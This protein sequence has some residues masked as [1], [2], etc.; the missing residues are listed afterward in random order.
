MWQHHFEFLLLG[1]RRL[2]DVRRVLQAGA[3]GHPRPAHRPDGRR[4][5][6]GAVPGRR[7]AAP[8]RAARDRHGRRAGVRRGPHAR[9]RST[10][11]S[12]RATRAA[13]ARGARGDQGPVVQH[14][15]G[16]RA[17]PLLRQLARRPEHPVRVARRATSARSRRAGDIERPTE[18][19][20]RERDRLAEEY[21]A[22][23][24]EEQRGP[25]QEL[26][27]PLA[28]GLPVR[29]GAQVL[30]R[31]LVPDRASSTRCASSAPC[32]RSTATSR[33][34][35]TSSSSRATRSCRRSRSSSL[36]WATGGQPLGPNHWPPIVARRKELLEQ[37]RR[38]DPAAGARHDARGGERP[39]RGDALGHHAGAPAGSG[40]ATTRAT[41]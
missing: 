17:L 39:D 25:F 18:E 7:R 38:L 35:R 12:P 28:H 36:H 13:L 11:S 41:S 5:R 4:H 32:S 15:H 8:A 16:R 31:L 6:R 3:A 21:G 2:P 1:L 34:P 14:G 30:L 23:L 37:A 29:R 40:R 9:T 24:A 10:R 19:L 20:A 22:L 33:T 27:G 26:L